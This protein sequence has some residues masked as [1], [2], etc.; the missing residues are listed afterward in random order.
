MKDITKHYN[1]T[2]ELPE[3]FT[4]DYSEFT[5][6]YELRRALFALGLDGIL[7]AYSSDFGKLSIDDG[8]SID[9]GNKTFYIVTKHGKIIKF[10]NSE[11]GSMS[12]VG[13]VN[14]ARW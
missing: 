14:L 5:L 2:G 13:N 4:A 6:N 3:S 11:W 7:A 10:T 12:N 1:E 8:K 9:I